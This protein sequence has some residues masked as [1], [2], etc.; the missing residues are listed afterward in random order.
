M[1]KIRRIRHAM[2]NVL[3]IFL[4]G[5]FMKVVSSDVAMLMSSLSNPVSMTGGANF[6]AYQK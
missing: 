6:S 5:R 4:S 1:A 2:M 3:A